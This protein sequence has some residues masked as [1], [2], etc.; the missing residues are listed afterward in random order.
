MVATSARPTPRSILL[1]VG[2]ARGDER[3]VERA[4]QLTKQWNASLTILHVVDS[5]AGGQNL[6]T[7]EIRDLMS[8]EFAEHPQSKGFHSDL[9]VA[10]GDPVEQLLIK[11]K[12]LNS[13]MIVMGVGH[14][15][16]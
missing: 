5:S 9:Q 1:A 15:D 7:D 11:L 6:T 10:R 4:F 14:H 2:S 16:N 13:D 3:A 12:Q 8:R